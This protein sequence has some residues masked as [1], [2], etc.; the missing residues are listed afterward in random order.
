MNVKVF[1]LII[2]ILIFEESNS[3]S[4]RSKIND[5]I[6]KAKEFYRKQFHKD[7]TWHFLGYDKTEYPGTDEK[8][9]NVNREKWQEYYDCLK[10]QEDSL[11]NHGSIIPEALLAFQ[12]QLIT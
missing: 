5:L 8:L 1:Y 12:G 9:L 11:E 3:F 10:K 6:K 2:A 4:F 7:K